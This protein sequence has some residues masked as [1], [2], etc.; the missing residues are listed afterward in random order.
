MSLYHFQLPLLLLCVACFAQLTHALNYTHFV[1][2]MMPYE[3]IARFA[4]ITEAGERTNTNPLT[5]NV[6][7]IA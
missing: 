3:Y 7:V 5:Y 4:F 1:D 6:C 2:S